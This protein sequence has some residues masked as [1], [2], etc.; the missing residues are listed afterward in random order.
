M[1]QGRFGQA[2]GGTIFLDEVGELPLELQPKLLRVLQSGEFERVGGDRTF[3][4][5]VRVVA[6]THRDLEAEVR[7]GRFREDLFYRL[8]VFPIV[9]PPLRRRRDDIPRLVEHFVPILAKRADRT[10]DEV[11]GSVLRQ[12]TDY[13]WPGNVRELIS[14]LERA[15][16]TSEGGVLRLSEPLDPGVSARLDEGN[17]AAVTEPLITLEENE[18]RHILRAL[19]ACGG[20][21]SGAGGAAELL[22][23]NPSTLRTRMKKLRLRS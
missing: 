6:A 12:L 21:I 13:A 18:R 15:V 7:A 11:P 8:N 2:A 14:V 5:D 4:A 10:I 9:V 22:G 23:I 20:K 17:A 16:V 19:E 1:R 3:T